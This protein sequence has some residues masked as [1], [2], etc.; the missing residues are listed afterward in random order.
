MIPVYNPIFTEDDAKAVYDVVISQF[1]T[2]IGSETKQLENI[3]KNEYY[4]KYAL[5]CSNG[6]AALHLALVGLNLER[7]TI[8]VPACSFAAV[9]FAPAYVNCKTVFIDADQRTWNMDLGLLEEE[10][11]KQ[12]IDAVI[13]VHNY[14]NVYDYNKLKELSDRYKFFI[15]EDAC[16]A[17]GSWY[18]DYESGRLGDVSVFS[19][20][21]NK[22]LSI[23]GDT[24]LYVKIN[25]SAK[26]I[27][28]CDLNDID[29]NSIECASFNPNNGKITWVKINDTIIHEY[30]GNIF[31]IYS[32]DNR[33]VDVTENHSLFVYRNEN[34]IPIESS[35][36]S[37][38]DYL[39]CPRSIPDNSTDIVIDITD[40]IKTEHGYRESLNRFINVDERLCRL[41]GY[42]IAEG[43][44][45]ANNINFTFNINEVEYHNDMIS[46]W[47]EIFDDWSISKNDNRHNATNLICGGIIHKELFM[48]LCGGSS[49]DKN[50]PYFAFNLSYSNKLELIT[51]I[52][53]GDGCV[54]EVAGK[55][56][57]EIKT[58]SKRLA[59]E[60]QYLI[61]SM[62]HNSALESNKGKG[63]RKDSYS[64]IIGDNI[65]INKLLNSNFKTK[66]ANKTDLIPIYGF[67]RKHVRQDKIDLP[68]LNKDLCFLKIKKI[69]LLRSGTETV[70]D[71]SVPN[72]FENFIGG[73]GGVC[74]HNSGGE[75]G[76][77][78]TDLE[79]VNERASLFRSQALSRKR[80]FWH[81]AIGHNFRITNMQ[82]A[83]I[84]SQYKR[85]LDLV[86]RSKEVANTYIKNMP[87]VL[88]TQEECHNGN[89]CW[90]MFSVVHPEKPHF[91]E[92]ASELLKEYGYDTR[93]IFQPMPKMPPWLDQ[94]N[95]NKYP[96]SEWI[97]DR[98]ITLPSG[99]G[100]DFSEIIKICDVIKEACF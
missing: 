30:N 49:Y 25:G 99:P 76:M 32:D 26:L 82:S 27:N 71:L 5:A 37:I 44:S 70:Y 31:R 1:V 15:I 97:S 23:T 17:M 52:W 7:K 11:K 22:M 48:E 54:H 65:L 83:L 40:Y 53:R 58:I 39:V 3:F 63:N 84:I 62:G 14:G 16:E 68:F 61:L 47:N 77:L 75:G 34:I 8:A 2:H 38:N 10:C 94:E 57:C 73:Y 4:R 33:Y 43:S 36:L 72:H 69:E 55:T 100:L 88:R 98:G 90:W 18:G 66:Q 67:R 96:V 93:P 56:C 28:A 74:L 92:I 80:R 51:G 79:F 35:K 12:R 85:K 6:T 81:E 86:K 95:G 42:Y 41:L 64:I 50:L 13:A 87:S 19:F 46:L 21:G 9:G 20:Y 89:N 29:K 91:Y 24:P 45:G 59:S 60:L 78:L